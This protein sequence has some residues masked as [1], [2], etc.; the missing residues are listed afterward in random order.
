MTDWV[1]LGSTPAQ[2]APAVSIVSANTL[3][4]TSAAVVAGDSTVS[5]ANVG[6]ANVTRL[7]VTA[8]AAAPGTVG[9]V[10]GSGAPGTVIASQST[11]IVPNSLSG[12]GNGAVSTVSVNPSTGKLQRLATPLGG[13]AVVG[14]CD[15]HGNVALQIRQYVG[16]APRLV[17]NVMT[18]PYSAVG[19]GVTDDTVAIQRAADAANAALV[20]C[21]A[22][23]AGAME[24][25]PELFFPRGNYLIS[26][27][28]ELQ[29]WIAVR[30]DKNA[31][32][33]GATNT[34][35]LFR[36]GAF[37]NSFDGLMFVGGKHHITMYGPAPHFGGALG[38]PAAEGANFITNCDFRYSSEPSIYIDTTLVGSGGS[39]SSYIP[40]DTSVYFS[41]CN[42][43]SP[44][45]LYGTCDG[46]FFTDCHFL[47][48]ESGTRSTGPIN[49]MNGHRMA[50]FSSSGRL[51][52]SNCLG[53]PQTLD[54]TSAW[55]SGGS[56]I[57]AYGTRF[58]GETQYCLI[59]IRDNMP[60]NGMPLVVGNTTADVHLDFCEITG[61]GTSNWMEV[62]DTFPGSITLTRGVTNFGLNSE[63]YGIWVDST[64][65][66]ASTFR[67]RNYQGLQI[68]IP[69]QQGYDSARIYTSAAPPSP[70]APAGAVELVPQLRNYINDYRPPEVP[71]A[72][73]NLWLASD[74]APDATWTNGST[75]GSF[76]AADTTTGY[77][78]KKFSATANG[79]IAA[80]TS[81]SWNCSTAGE[82]TF[83]VW[84][85]ATTGLR[86]MLGY[87][88]L[89]KAIRHLEQAGE[90][91]R[92]GFQ[93]WHDGS[94]A[95]LFFFNVYQM[96]NASGFW[97][98]L[99]AIHAGASIS[100]YTFP[101]DSPNSPTTNVTVEAV[102]RG[103]YWGA[104]APAS[105]T[106]KIGDIVW[107]SAPA[108][109]GNIGWVCTVSGSPGT[110]FAFGAIL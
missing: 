53:V 52:F 96:A 13:E 89:D 87:N 12:L 108:H 56:V 76:G 18:A 86:P 24:T 28:I 31:T 98:G 51:A 5:A 32:V 61:T 57:T 101:V 43:F 78:L 100:P 110:W 65:C 36:I 25:T 80:L 55:I 46:F 20:A 4:G 45:I 70:P 109:S 93:F 105:G 15:A 48:D 62:Y 54:N 82:Y 81:P 2:V 75:N 104:S 40:A 97:V 8:L 77:S 26:S 10:L 58:G 16:T 6:N 35:T 103:T 79:A 21:A 49:D 95:K 39:F 68:S 69:G 23:S 14:A 99:P 83:S 34:F 63:S 9:V 102:V 90:W 64:S 41:H 27:Q 59:R 50:C 60:Y 72:K 38:S 92:L 1:I 30:G 88:S 22:N 107:H 42:F 67:D 7:T 44:T 94:T 29:D 37:H 17:F 47:W 66:A 74:F 19:D 85:K 106:Y 11:G 84:V 71:A 3:D 33:I 73:N 91:S